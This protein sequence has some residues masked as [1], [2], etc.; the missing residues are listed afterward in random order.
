MHRNLAADRPWLMLERQHK[1]MR[2]FP[3]F[4]LTVGIFSVVGALSG[5]GSAASSVTTVSGLI[6]GIAL[7]SLS[8]AV[9]QKRQAALWIGHSVV[10]IGLVSVIAGAFQHG[11]SLPPW[12]RYAVISASVIGGSLVGIYWAAAWRRLWTRLSGLNDGGGNVAGGS[13]G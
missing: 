9:W 3:S 10:V 12:E 4:F 7:V 13:G 8:L 5:V 6:I 2:F 11:I 1:I